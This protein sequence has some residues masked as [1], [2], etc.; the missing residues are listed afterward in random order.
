MVV[1]NTICVLFGNCKIVIS[2]ISHCSG[3]ISHPDQSPVSIQRPSFPGMGIPK[4]KIR[5]LRDLLIFY[6][7]AWGSLYWWDNIFILR[8]PPGSQTCAPTFF[9][10]SYLLFP[11]NQ[12]P[13][14]YLSNMCIYIYI[15][16]IYMAPA[17]NNC[18]I[19]NVTV[20]MSIDD[21]RLYSYDRR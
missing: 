5:R 14:Q 15:Y 6:S 2:V 21:S 1:A 16:I 8:R 3:R 4:S 18:Q 17:R 20:G 19:C 7:L 13:R 9:H 11:T 10:Q 12:S